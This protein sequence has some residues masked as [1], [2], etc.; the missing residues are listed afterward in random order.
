MISISFVNGEQESLLA[1]DPFLTL[2]NAMLKAS[3]EIDSMVSSYMKTREDYLFE[4]S[5]LGF[6]DEE[7][8][9][10]LESGKDNIFKKIG[11]AIIAL[12][13]KFQDMV[14]G[15]IEKIKD[16]GFKA[17]TD[18][19]KLEKL[20]KTHPEL[21]DEVICAYKQGDL[22][23]ADAKTLKELDSAFDEIIQMSK[24]KDVKPDTLRGKV[25]AFKKKVDSIDKST[26]VKVAG[27]T[28]AV[29]TAGSAIFMFKKHLLDSKKA[30]YEYQK[31]CAEKNEK[32]AKALKD[33]QDHGKDEYGD[34]NAFI[35][36]CL[37][38]SQIVKN[39]E[40]IQEGLYSKLIAKEQ[41]KVT[42]FFNGVTDFIGKHMKKESKNYV[43][44]L[45][46]LAEVQSRKEQE[47][48]KKTFDDSRLKS[49]A[50]EVGK[51]DARKSKKN[52]EAYAQA[53]LDDAYYT[54]AGQV[55]YDE[56]HNYQDVKRRAD[57]QAQTQDSYI[58]DRDDD[59][60]AKN[61]NKKPQTIN[62]KILKDK[63]NT[64]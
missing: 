55:D 21:K 59:K 56:Q 23:V 61:K 16:M 63:N 49:H 33:L 43:E 4:S 60:E 1:S 5:F 14:K 39:L 22:N 48:K 40:L 54:K 2:E 51:L 47:E 6:E 7:K 20:L 27:A 17:K 10:Y 64:N 42:K 26:V 58:R 41:G 15:V 12:F 46:K 9:L 57:I 34:E 19:E 62:V 53:K 24:K 44:D 25:E 45:K 50:N 30:T 13:K 36:D 29:I 18:T 35:S 11:D 28:T 32:S 31:M 3:D 37:S 38:K 52:R 8:E